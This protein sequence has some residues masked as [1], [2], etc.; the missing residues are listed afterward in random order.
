MLCHVWYSKH[1]TAAANL[2]CAVHGQLIIIMLH[3]VCIAGVEFNYWM[4][5]SIIML[6]I[7]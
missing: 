5:N 4:Y 6:T 3:D 2:P 7:I 1:F